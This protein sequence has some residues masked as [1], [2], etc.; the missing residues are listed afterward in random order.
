MILRYFLRHDLIELEKKV[1]ALQAEIVEVGSRI[2][3]ACDQGAETYHDNAPFEEAVRHQ[4]ILSAQLS[5]ILSI[6]RGAQPIDPPQSPKTVCVGTK[7]LVI[8]DNEEKPVELTIGSFRNALN[9]DDIVSY[10]SPLGQSLIGAKPGD[11]C[12]YVLQK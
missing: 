11:S 6:L 9:E 2:S 3:E 8:F 12:S 4:Q 5:N 10:V 1:R 7:V